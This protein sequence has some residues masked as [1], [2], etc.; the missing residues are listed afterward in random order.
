MKALF[1]I[2]SKLKFFSPGRKKKKTPGKKEKTGLPVDYRDISQRE[3]DFKKAPLVADLERNLRTIMEITGNSYDLSI[4]KCQIGPE[5]V[6]AA[7]IFID[8]MIEKFAIEN[9]LQALKLETF[10]TGIDGINKK[11]IFATLL[12]SLLTE[13]S[14]EADDIQTLYEG[15]SQGETALLF[16]GTAKAILCETRGWS[17]RTIVEPENES[18]IRAPREGFVESVRV[19]TSLIRR[20]IRSPNLWIEN[21]YVGSLTR[22]EVAFA[23]IKGLAGEEFLEELRSRLKRIDIDGILESGVVEEFIRDAP[24]S[25]FPTVFRTE[26]PDRVASAI[27]EGRVAIFTNGTPFVLVVPADLLMMLQAPDDYFEIFP[28]G[29]FLRILRFISF[30]LSFFLPGIY[31]ALL[32]FH[33]EL[34]PITLLLRIQ[35]AREGVPFPVVAE[36]LLM[37][38]TFEILRE[39]G[40]RL[41][42]AVGAAITIVG[43]L[44]LG[45]AAIRAGIVSPGV[46]IIVAFTAIA[47]FT[48]PVFSLALTARLIRFGMIFLG[49]LIGLLGIQFGLLVLIVHLVSMR[50]FGYPYMA[51][52]GPLI[53]Q[54]M[55]DAVIRGFWWKQTY[56]PRLL[57]FREPLRQR[58]GQMPRPP[59]KSNYSDKNGGKDE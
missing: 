39:A 13:I 58:P 42:R 34:V 7:V 4:K 27:L 3:E 24:F 44:I 53:W 46:V 14:R 25:L 43:A 28:I 17:L 41:P 57:G 35:A 10:K 19:N 16:D 40:V 11:E 15:V 33:P 20:R 45:D 51:P 22:T 26:R 8:G 56:R 32:N 2:F 9:L 23:Y 6:P 54:D 31:V 38:A 21:L 30:L 29:L 5:K 1:R 48:S 12:N 49:A 55:K 52:F 18:A 50:S 47:S 37:E 59:R 36:V